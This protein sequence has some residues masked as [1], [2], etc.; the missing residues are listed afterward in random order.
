MRII[1]IF[2]LILTIT[3]CS[4]LTQKE[5]PP[6]APEATLPKREAAV[7][8]VQSWHIKG[9]IAVQTEKDS[10]SA[11]VNWSQRQRNYSISLQGPMG[12][13]AMN[14]TGN[15]GH[16]TMKTS[17]GKIVSAS[18]PEQLLAEQWGFKLPVS[19]M[20]YWVRGLQVPGIPAETHYDQFNRLTRMTQQGWT[21]QY[22]SYS[23]NGGVD[24]PQKL[25][26]TSPA[27]KVKLV[28]YSWNA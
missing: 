14:L 5:A 10:G 21:I 28:I 13:N 27:M 26:I 25:S 2:L 24:L 16:V 9:K 20:R 23:N 19:N 3:S 7:D 1:W 4:T 11:S 17:D 6:A 8:R 15:A 18:S 12:S 22:L